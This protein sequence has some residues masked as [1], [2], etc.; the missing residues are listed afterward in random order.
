M[1][2]EE[3]MHERIGFNTKATCPRCR[4][5]YGMKNPMIWGNVYEKKNGILAQQFYCVSC[6]DTYVA[7]YRSTDMIFCS[8]DKEKSTPNIIGIKERSVIKD[9]K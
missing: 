6:N 2:N 1:K 4:V 9:E 3:E 8:V 7:E 5:M